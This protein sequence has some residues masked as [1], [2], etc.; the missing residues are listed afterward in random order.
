MSDDVDTH[1]LRKYNVQSKLG[2]GVRVKQRRHAL[3]AACVY[4][5]A[6][7]GKV[8]SVLVLPLHSFRRMASCGK[9]LT[10]GPATPSR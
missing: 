7:R 2:K 5:H 4:L 9:L 1:V 10:S 6:R 8:T 3:G